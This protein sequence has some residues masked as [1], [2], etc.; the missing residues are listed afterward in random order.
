[1]SDGPCCDTIKILLQFS[2]LSRTSYIPSYSHI[3]RNNHKERVREMQ[4][5]NGE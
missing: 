5:S 2:V 1:L 3:T 4:V